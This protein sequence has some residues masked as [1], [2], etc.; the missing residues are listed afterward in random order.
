MIWTHSASLKILR[1]GILLLYDALRPSSNFPDFPHLSSLHIEDAV[2]S[3]YIVRL[4][5]EIS[6]AAVAFILHV[7]ETI[8]TLQWGLSVLEETTKLI[9]ANHL[10][11][12][13]QL[14]GY[15]IRQLIRTHSPRKLQIIA[16]SPVDLGPETD[17]SLLRETSSCLPNLS[18]LAISTQIRS[19]QVLH[20]LRTFTNLMELWYEE[21]PGCE[22]HE[23]ESKEESRYPYDLFQVVLPALPKLRDLCI[24][25]KGD[26][27]N[28]APWDMS[29]RLKLYSQS[30]CSVTIQFV[31]HG[32]AGYGL[33]VFRENPESIWTHKALNGL[34]M[35]RSFE[36]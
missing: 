20:D 7:H 30:L 16:L 14:S 22:P 34:H 9:T 3:P 12:L 29:G 24:S 27:S 31:V 23:E 35:M 10:P 28:I 26:I 36:V 15:R 19:M 33:N 8:V 5:P 2:G 13:S 1:V 17:G 18:V 4:D 25:I 11:N 32:V 21:E 6:F